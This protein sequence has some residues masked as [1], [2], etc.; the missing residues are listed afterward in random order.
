MY[1]CLFLSL[2]LCMYIYIY[3]NKNLTTI[4]ITTHS[5]ITKTTAALPGLAGGVRRRAQVS[6][7]PRAGHGQGSREGG[8]ALG[9]L[10]IPF[11]DL[12]Y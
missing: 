2:S 3:D 5:T 1:V 8:E 12:L 6:R 9:F 7:G 4:T 11:G 10:W